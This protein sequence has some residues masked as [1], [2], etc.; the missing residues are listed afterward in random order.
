M[1]QKGEDWRGRRLRERI[2][3]E[4]ICGSEGKNPPD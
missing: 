1:G 3:K 4:Q 2:K